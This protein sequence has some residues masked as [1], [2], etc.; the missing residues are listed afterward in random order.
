MLGYTWGKCEVVAAMD[1]LSVSASI[2]SL[3]GAADTVVRRLYHYVKAVKGAEKQ[4][5]ALSMEITTLYGVLSS[6]HLVASRFES[7]SSELTMKERSMQIDHIHACYTTLDSIRSLLQ[8]DDP[9][10][11]QSRMESI[12]RRLHW[13]LSESK[14]KEFID[15]VG[16]HKQTLTLALNADTMAALLQ[17]LSQQKDISYG[18]EDIKNRMIASS[19]M[20]DR[21]KVLKSLIQ[22]VDP[23]KYLASVLRL[24][25]MGTGLWIRDSS[26][27][28]NWINSSNAR[29]FLTGIPGAGKTVLCAVIIEEILKRTQGG[30]TGSALAYYFCDYKDPATN[31]PRN[32]LASLVV[33]F[34]AQDEECYKVAQ[35]LYENHCLSEGSRSSYTTEDLKQCLLDM[36]KTL[37]HAFIVVDALDEC[38]NDRAS[39]LEILHCLNDFPNENTKTLYTGRDELDIQTALSDYDRF[40]MAANSHDIRLFVDSE[41]ARRTK[42]AT[43][44]IRDHALKE[45]IR[46]RLVTK[47]EGM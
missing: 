29:L 22:D 38:V 42:N 39:V 15:A 9:S 37:D 40:S 33:Q 10:T 28:Q 32:I 4:I 2:A 45:E 34:A 20:E 12:R 5:S 3:I 25:Q 31:D 27:F 36:V 14:T 13:P 46:E 6:L 23:H 47:A 18:I 17:G 43:L 21:R 41:I 11:T 1:P 8:K 44:R 16:R 30:K 26:Q 19:I 24:R 7:E 35:T